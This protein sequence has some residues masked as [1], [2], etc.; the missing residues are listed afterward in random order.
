MK[1]FNY[2]NLIENKKFKSNKFQNFIYRINE[3][4][5]IQF[6]NCF[7]YKTEFWQVKLKSTLFVNCDFKKNIFSDVEFSNTKFINCKFNESSFAHL[8]IKDKIFINCKFLRNKFNTV[9]LKMKNILPKKIFDKNS[10]QI[11]TF[12]E[13]KE[14]IKDLEGKGFN[15]K[16]TNSKHLDNSMFYVN[17]RHIVDK[18][19]KKFSKSKFS[20]N[21]FERKTN[22]KNIVHELIYGNG[23]VVL[24]DKIDNKY[25]SN[26]LKIL[27]KKN[28]SLKKF[29]TNKRNKQCYLDNLFA[30]DISF[31][32]ILPKKKFFGEIK[33]ILGENFTCGFYSANILAPGARSQPFHIDYPYPT[34]DRKNG[35]LV[36]FSY[37]N[38]IN[39]QIQIMMS[40]IK[41]KNGVGPTDIIPGTQ[42]L[43]QDPKYLEIYENRKKNEIYF[44]KKNKKFKYKIKSLEGSAG[45]TI[46]FNGLMWHRAGENASKEKMR[47]TLNMQLLSNYIRPMHKFNKIK[48][49]DDE[50]INQLSGYN[51]KLPLEV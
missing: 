47:I 25:L 40:E 4:S 13:K 42:F 44:Y 8:I 3:F 30:N 38:P 11:I 32:K 29:S 49:S 28:D 34:M 48:K 7:F 43:Q 46:L 26:A 9:T 15:F 51:L 33:K 45:K 10:D 41:K 6:E 39:I 22:F 20:F 1:K 12:S 16:K 5:N 23:Y 21:N 37:K 19:P 2:K 27:N 50:I 35:E 18:E 14:L 36:N 24:D 31:S 17:Y